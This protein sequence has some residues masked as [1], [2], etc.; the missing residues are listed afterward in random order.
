M[1]R[2]RKIDSRV[3]NDAKF[4]SLDHA[5]Q[6]AFFLL[7]SHPHMTSLGAMRATISGLVSES[8]L[9]AG[10]FRQAL[11][12]GLAEVDEK[13]SCVALPNFIKYNR[14]ESPNVIRFAWREAADLIPE[15]AL[16]AA[17]IARAETIVEGMGE[18]FRQAFREAFDK[19]CHKPT[20]NPEPEPEPE[21]FSSVASPPEEHKQGNG[22]SPP[23]STF[24][25]SYPPRRGRKRG[26]DDA[27]KVWLKLSTADRVAAVEDVTHRL[28]C[29]DQWRGGYVPDA[30]RYL[31]KRLW[32]D[33]RGEAAEIP[34]T[35][36]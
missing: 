26:R 19:A 27:E 24:W 21:P 25:E 22:S 2:F 7:L 6:L 10:A 18:G 32:T 35:P 31:R 23:F 30:H 29:D 17:Q 14:P 20:D 28:L 8:G 33:E 1:A 12:R 13:A 9:P 5:G 11:S 3:W 36:A 4:R 16:K 34:Y 15:C